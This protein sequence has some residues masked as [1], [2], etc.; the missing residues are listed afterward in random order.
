MNL[1]QKSPF[2][3]FCGTFT[4]LILMPVLLPQVRLLFLVPFLIIV[5]YQKSYAKALWLSFLC[6]L[7]LDLLNSHLLFGFYA[8]NY[9]LTTGILYGQ[10]RNFFAD[11]LSTMPLMAFFFALTSTLIQLLLIYIF[12]RELALSWKW[13][14]TDLFLMPLADALYAFSCFILPFYL[15]GKKPRRG[16]DYFL[17]A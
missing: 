14:L 3:V 15:F 12:D 17:K 4:A 13:A 6:G 5:Y 8:L 10:R 1:S 7:I 11:S 9:T 2:W 16:N